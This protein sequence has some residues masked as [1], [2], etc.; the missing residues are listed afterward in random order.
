MMLLFK[1]YVKLVLKILS[2]FIFFYL[3]YFDSFFLNQENI[4]IKTENTDW[5]ILQVKSYEQFFTHTGHN[6]YNNWPILLGSTL[7]GA[8]GGVTVGYVGDNYFPY[9]LDGWLKYSYRIFWDTIELSEEELNQPLQQGYI[10]KHF[11]KYRLNLSMESHFWTEFTE[12]ELKNFKDTFFSQGNFTS[13]DYYKSLPKM[14]DSGA[15][16]NC[17]SAILRDNPSFFMKFNQSHIV[18]GYKLEE[19]LNILEKL[20][21]NDHMFY[22]VGFIVGGVGFINWILFNT[23]LIDIF[24]KDQLFFL[25]IIENFDKIDLVQTPLKD[26]LL[27]YEGQKFNLNIETFKVKGKLFSEWIA[28]Y[29]R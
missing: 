8:V 23:E 2:L 4:S 22:S 18:S 16:F 10:N 17:W 19:W 7:L 29:K 13:T 24:L 26:I 25:W 20:F 15:D 14:F 21:I 27:S 3:F 1:S 5:F 6:L 28:Y 12:V 11:D 9:E